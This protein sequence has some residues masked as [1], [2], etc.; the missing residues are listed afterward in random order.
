MLNYLIKFSISLTVLYVFYRAVLR[1]L[2]FYRWNRFYLLGYALLSFFIPLIN[3]SDFI[4]RDSGGYET[5]FVYIP[6][7]DHI[8]GLQSL[9]SIPWWKTLTAAQWLLILFFTGVTVML[10]RFL[11]QMMALRRFRQKSRLL[12]NENGVAL[13]ETDAK[14]VPFSFG[15]SIFINPSSHNQEE[16][17]RIIQHEFVHV[18][19][20]HTIDLLMAELLCIVNW[21]NPFAW[22]VRHAIRQNLEFLA[23]DQVLKSGLEK[24]DYQYLLLK[25]TGNDG[26]A[27]AGH[28]NFSSLKKRIVM[29]NK[30]KSARVHGARFL[31]VLPLLAVSLL[32]FR[33]YHGDA[34]TVWLAGIVIDAQTKQPLQGATVSLSGT[35]LSVHPD[36]N[37]YYEIEIPYENKPLSFQLDISHN[38]YQA[39]HQTENWG[40]FYEQG[41][42]SQYRY[43]FEFFGMSKTGDGFSV[44]SKSVA[45]RQDLNG[46]RARDLLDA[47]L[48]EQQHQGV[49]IGMVTD[50]VPAKESAKDDEINIDRQRSKDAATGVYTDKVK[51]THGDG[52]IEEYDFTKP[53]G[54]AA[55]KKKYGMLEVPPPPPP[56]KK[57]VAQPGTPPPPAVVADKRAAVPP[58]PAVKIKVD[59]AP[60]PPPP[61]NAERKSGEAAPATPP[62]ANKIE[63][64]V[65]PVAANK[66]IG[67]LEPATPGAIYFVDGKE[68]TT[69]EVR[70]VI[71]DSVKSVI[72]WKGQ[73]ANKRFGEK[74]SNGVVEIRTK[75]VD[76]GAIPAD[77]L[78]FIDG[79]EMPKGTNV[80]E[81]LRPT[82][83]REMRVLQ[84]QDA[85]KK[86]GDRASK[87]V[88]EIT[89]ITNPNPQKISMSSGDARVT[90]FYTSFAVSSSSA[91]D[92]YEGRFDF[93][94]QQPLPLVVWEG[95]RFANITSFYTPRKQIEMT[96]LSK[97]DGIARYGNDAK[98]GVLEI[99]SL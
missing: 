75:V 69:D 21:F 86:Y 47:L 18:R 36:K 65:A 89:T 43:S 37:G 6:S 91:T 59:I 35:L 14:A 51:V 95:K 8:G 83:I 56:A 78:L 67:R 5:Y 72:V 13:Y 88:I 22:L 32:A 27:I 42:N 29:M 28:F 54:R 87:G 23:D 26:F 7:V 24:K 30:I 71:A 33:S 77:V 16:L 45:N 99:K 79:K 92:A 64:R 1:P 97:A 17:E 12:S 76:V 63:K 38:G 44:L 15:R 2:T 85:L 31:F 25:V 66:P 52:T 49:R 98:N 9:A 39:I 34:K 58:E 53:A 46:Q 93:D 40:N 41:V 73:E 84:G 62:P 74:G 48:K 3:I 90:M 10:I 70:R 4:H 80:N 61:A 81:I 96:L 57:A 50:T 11:L 55:F 68:V 20:L 94:Q 19:Q 60:P 82:D